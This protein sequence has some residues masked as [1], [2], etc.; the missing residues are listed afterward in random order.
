MRKNIY[1][2]RLIKQDNYISDYII[3][4]EKIELRV[5]FNYSTTLENGLMVHEI[6]KKDN[7]PLIIMG[8]SG[9]GSN[10]YFNNLFNLGI[11]DE[12]VIYK[13]NRKYVYNINKVL[14]FDKGKK[15]KIENNADKLY[16]VTCDLIN[17]QKQWVFSSKLAKIEEI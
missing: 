8:H 10:V 9:I 16:L 11:N 2:D 14:V 1:K 5:H 7:N 12:I 17:M 3:E 15:I 4:I 6:S 13:E